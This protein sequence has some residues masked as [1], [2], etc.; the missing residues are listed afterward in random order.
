MAAALAVAGITSGSAPAQTYPAKS[1]RYIVPFPPGGGQDLVVRALAPRMSE[2]L[3]Q[4]V[5]VDNR[6]GAATMLGA[7]LAAKAAPDGYTVFNGSNTTLAI[8]P[9]LYTRVPY[10]PIKDFVP[11]TQIATLP[12]L[13]VVHPSLP[14]RTVKELANLAR[15][16]PNQL[17]Y[18]SSG[19][20]TP[21]QL[22][23]VMFADEARAKLVHV[24]YRG[25][26]PALT[27]LISGETQ[28]M[29]S[30]M[31]S[32]LP[33]V[34]SGRLRAI[35]VTGAKRSLAAPE[36]PTVAEA[37]FPGF[38]AVTWYGLFVPAGTPAAIIGRLNIEVVKILRAPDFRDWLVAQG[39]DPAGS[40]PDE[41]AAFVKTELA[42]YAKLVKDSGM[43]PD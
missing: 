17:N 11:V 20:G 4:N 32:T 38:E 39:A 28:I 1:I 25:S 12:N 19:T 30:S 43:R 8:N 7:E 35:A 23:G 9:N 10:D 18:G 24:P 14:V 36:L 34:K 31:T 41:L 26:S 42:K 16:R 5:V 37:A 21:A 29:F 22:A 13:L 6:P 2:A 3:G 33:F 15:N 40:T 27:A